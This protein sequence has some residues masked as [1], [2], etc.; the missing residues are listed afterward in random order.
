LGLERLDFGIDQR[1]AVVLL[2]WKGEESR[3]IVGAP[4]ES[5]KSIDSIDLIAAAYRSRP[6]CRRC[7]A[8][9]LDLWWE[10]AISRRRRGGAGRCGYRCCGVGWPTRRPHEPHAAPGCPS[11]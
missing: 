5:F 8:V 11:S 6:S 3:D 4:I 9:R 2:G 1:H 7:P 10:A